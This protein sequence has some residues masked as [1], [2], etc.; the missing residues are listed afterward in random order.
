MRPQQFPRVCDV[1]L[2]RLEMTNSQP[3]H[4]TIVETRV[5]QKHLARGI[6]AV[7]QA[8]IE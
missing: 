7:Q 3:Q 8:F 2:T 5:R 1:V 4:E 6:H